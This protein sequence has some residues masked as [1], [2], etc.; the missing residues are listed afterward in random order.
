MH[1]SGAKAPFGVDNLFTKLIFAPSHPNHRHMDCPKTDHGSIARAPTYSKSTL[2]TRFRFGDTAFPGGTEGWNSQLR[3]ATG[4]EDGD[5]S[6]AASKS[7]RQLGTTGSDAGAPGGALKLTG[8]TPQ[9][10]PPRFPA[11]PALG[12]A[13]LIVN[14]LL[15]L[16]AEMYPHA[17]STRWNEPAF[18]DNACVYA[19]DRKA[20]QPITDRVGFNGILQ[21]EGLLAIGGARSA[22]MRIAEL[23]T[24]RIG[25]VVDRWP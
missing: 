19:P 24:L 1:K 8:P 23:R 9:Y 2:D 17:K 11:Q 18:K 21:V 14:E 12:T 25:I 20:K 16:L 10:D 7:P 3:F 6:S 4:I 22:M 5:I 15:L 13:V